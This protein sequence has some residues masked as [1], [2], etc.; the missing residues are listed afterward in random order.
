MLAK[1]ELRMRYIVSDK[2]GK[3]ELPLG[4]FQR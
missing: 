3:S 4:A 2:P 1:R